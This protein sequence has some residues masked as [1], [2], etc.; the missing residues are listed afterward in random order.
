MRAL[1]GP[2]EYLVSL[3]PASVVRITKVESKWSRVLIPWVHIWV[4][5]E[6][7]DGVIR[8]K[9]NVLFIK[10]SSLKYL[11]FTINVWWTSHCQGLFTL[12]INVNA[13]CDRNCIKSYKSKTNGFTDVTE[14]IFQN[15]YIIVIIDTYI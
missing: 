2:E 10:S 12:S 11:L 4:I 1:E 15:K 3:S 8:N 7:L 6:L 5:N 13:K 14:L 9:E